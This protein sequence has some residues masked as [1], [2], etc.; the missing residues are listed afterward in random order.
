[1]ISNN[2]QQVGL[3]INLLGLSKDYI[4]YIQRF[5]FRQKQNLWKLFQG[6]E[7]SENIK[8]GQSTVTV[9]FFIISL[10]LKIANHSDSICHTAQD[11][12]CKTSLQF[13]ICSVS[14]SFLL[15]YPLIC[16]VS[17]DFKN[18]RSCPKETN[19]L[20]TLD[21]L[22]CYGYESYSLSGLASE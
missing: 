4:S 17:R 20:I 14:F 21:F 19:R 6:R 1:M 9:F 11:F 5:K 18:A 15:P 12:R 3:I 8:R 2:C 22:N 16:R 10:H 13:K 7:Y